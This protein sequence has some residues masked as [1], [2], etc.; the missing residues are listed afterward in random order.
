MNIY[1][2]F[3]DNCREVFE[4]Y[5]SVFGGEFEAL[6]TFADAPSD[7][8]VPDEAKSR[9]MHITLPLGEDRLM[10]SDSMP[11]A[12][13][14]LLIGNNFSIVVPAS[15]RAQC[16]KYFS[17]LSGDGEI[18]MPL[19]ETFWGSYFGRCRDRYQINWMFN[20]DLNRAAK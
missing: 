10:G 2:T 16:D 4:F 6:Q 5:R 1:L 12:S 11:G 7:M 20:F 14:P 8:P 15:S 13:T 3:E 9:L 19:Q 17:A 18:T